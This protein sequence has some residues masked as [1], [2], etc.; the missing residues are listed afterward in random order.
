MS[1]GFFA[2]RTTKKEKKTDLELVK[3]IFNPVVTNDL[4][5]N[6]KIYGYP[7]YLDTLA[8]Y[9]NVNIFQDVRGKLLKEKKLSDENYFRQGPSNWNQ[10][11]D[12]VRFLTVRNGNDLTSPAIAL[13]T[14]DVPYYQDILAALMLQNKTKMTTDDFTAANFQLPATKA[15]GETEYPGIKALEFYT[16]FARPGNENYT[17][18]PKFGS[19][20]GAFFA[21]KLP[22]LIQYGAFEKVLKQM[23]PTLEY[24]TSPLPQVQGNQDPIDY[25]RYLAY[26]V[27]LGSPHKTEA[28]KFIKYFDTKGIALYLKGTKFVGANIVKNPPT[29]YDRTF[30]KN[31][32]EFQ[33]LSAQSWHKGAEPMKVDS[34]FRDMINDVTQKNVP[35]QTAVNSAATRITEL[36]RTETKKGSN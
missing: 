29:M 28:W 6:N 25:G 21:G 20:E 3:K 19:A 32:F 35:A 1:T 12:Y 27:P 18:D 13:G 8:L 5:I 26:V 16:Q 17:W 14:S 22:M 23:A 10:L 2:D 15:T 24:Q 7:L 9:Y 30:K 36:L 11:V 33:G 31:P 4:V 34:I